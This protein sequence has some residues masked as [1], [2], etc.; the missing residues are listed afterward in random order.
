MFER[1]NESELHRLVNQSVHSSLKLH[2]NDVK[3]KSS[4]N[5]VLRTSIQTPVMKEYVPIQGLP[6]N[7]TN[8]DRFQIHMR[9]RE[10]LRECMLMVEQEEVV[11]RKFYDIIIRIR[12]DSFV[13]KALPILP[14]LHSGR[15]T[16]DKLVCQ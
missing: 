8:K 6:E 16:S 13:L 7:C 12:E 15:V 9:W 1:T 5:F 3:N 14:W 10:S 11:Q 2:T 4:G